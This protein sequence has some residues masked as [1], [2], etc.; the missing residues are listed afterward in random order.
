MTQSWPLCRLVF[1]VWVPH[2]SLMCPFKPKGTIFH[3]RL[4]LGLRLGLFW[5]VRVWPADSR[6]YSLN[7]STPMPNLCQLLPHAM[8][9]HQKARPRNTQ[10]S[11]DPYPKPEPAASKK[12]FPPPPPP[13]GKPQNKQKQT[14]PAHPKTQPYPKSKCKKKAKARKS[15][16]TRGS[17]ITALRST[18]GAWCR[19][20]RRPLA[21]STVLGFRV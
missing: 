3:P 7:P 17:S 12:D 1:K 4:L 18:S 8:E 19:R 11:I 14:P 10:H 13:K 15:R 2:G 9:S 21:P 6:L 5:G 20:I 16:R